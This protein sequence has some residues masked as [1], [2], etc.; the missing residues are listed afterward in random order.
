[1]VLQTA[2][3]ITRQDGFPIGLATVDDDP[4]GPAVALERL[5]QEPFGRTE[6]AL[7]A[8]SELDCVAITVDGPIKARSTPA[9]FDICLVDVPLAGDGSLA[10]VEPLQQ[11]GRVAHNPAMHGRVIDGDASLG[12][13]LLKIAQ[14]QIVGQ[15][16]PDKV[17][18]H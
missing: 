9:D 17:Q 12:H 3:S 13:D 5:A 10:P 2:L 15:I 18:D 8:E 6:V 7:L 14:A 16:P 1:M 4:L 11:F